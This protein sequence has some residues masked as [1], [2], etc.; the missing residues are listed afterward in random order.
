MSACKKKR[1]KHVGDGVYMKTYK[2]RHSKYCTCLECFKNEV[3]GWM[4]GGE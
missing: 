2:K 1:A 4:K 3:F